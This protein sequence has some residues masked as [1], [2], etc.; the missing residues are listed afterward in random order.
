MKHINAFMFFASLTAAFFFAA[1]YAYG[2]VSEKDAITYGLIALI[3]CI[4]FGADTCICEEK[5][6]QRK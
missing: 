2:F 3:L 6:A 1:G 4:V 5:E